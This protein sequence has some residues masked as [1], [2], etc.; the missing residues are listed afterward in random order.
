M[1]T[2]LTYNEQGKLSFEVV[3]IKDGTKQWVPI[4][5]NEVYIAKMQFPVGDKNFRVVGLGGEVQDA[6]FKTYNND[7]LLLKTENE[8]R[9]ALEQVI[10][11]MNYTYN[12]IE[13]IQ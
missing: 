1:K 9:Q 7:M 4:F 13:V 2:Q 12:G 5:E 10:I 11:T 8:V 6:F 3:A